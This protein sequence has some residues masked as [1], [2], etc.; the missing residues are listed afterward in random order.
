MAPDAPQPPSRCQ[1]NSPG[2]APGAVL[3]FRRNGVMMEGDV[4]RDD[5]TPVPHA[6][7]LIE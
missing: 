4:L 7:S 1:G 6:I 2:A 5:D 3:L